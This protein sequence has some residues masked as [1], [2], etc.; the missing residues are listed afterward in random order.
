MSQIVRYRQY[1]M[2][3]LKDRHQCQMCGELA[4]NAFEFVGEEGI[5]ELVTWLC[6]NCIN[7]AKIACI[8]TTNLIIWPFREIG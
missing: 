5:C 8:R 2:A 7:E 3:T 1:W 4:V 6:D